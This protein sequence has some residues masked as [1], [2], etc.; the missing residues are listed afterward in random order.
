MSR[1]G[2]TPGR[3]TPPLS[4]T[5]RQ[6]GER[7]D[8]LEDHSI[9][10]PA[11]TTD[12]GPLMAA[13]PAL[14]GFYPTEALVAVHLR[15]GHL[16]RLTCSAL[17]SPTL[18]QDCTTPLSVLDADTAVVLVCVTRA[19]QP[20]DPRPYGHTL[21][22]AADID[23][24][25]EALSRAGTHVLHALWLPAIV[26]AERWYSYDKWH[27]TGLLPHPA[28]AITLTTAAGLGQA[29]YP[30]RS[31]ASEFLV[32]DEP[33][34]LIRRAALMAQLT[35]NGTSFGPFGVIDGA[36]NNAAHHVLPRTDDSLVLLALAVSSASTRDAAMAMTAARP[37][38]GSRLWA[39]LARA[40]PEPQRTWPAAI[41]GYIAFLRR[42]YALATAALHAA[43]WADPAHACAS[44]ILEALARGLDP[45]PFQVI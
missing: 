14:L 19:E 3:H 17:N 40:L 26:V 6:I 12:P 37:E 31:R 36:L 41:L 38:A 8:V 32:P 1:R 2:R 4:H 35:G 30:K 9:S 11:W 22:R 44:L 15:N 25:R 29:T 16:T 43:L 10:L 20:D 21:P 23:S 27:L 7:P 34:A 18:V 42:D 33:S 5:S 13:I 28:F 24:V 39:T 45:A